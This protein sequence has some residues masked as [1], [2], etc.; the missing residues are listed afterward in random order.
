MCLVCFVKLTNCPVSAFSLVDCDVNINLTTGIVC[1][2]LC[3]VETLDDLFLKVNWC[4]TFNLFYKNITNI[5]LIWLDVWMFNLWFGFLF[6][7][8][9]CK[10]PCKHKST[11]IG[12]KWRKLPMWASYKKFFEYFVND[13]QCC[14][15]CLTNFFLLFPLVC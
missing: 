4:W 1:L 9:H 14:A 7:G 11:P 8:V 15:W 6:F 2:R 5:P 12:R 3:F 13:I 10:H